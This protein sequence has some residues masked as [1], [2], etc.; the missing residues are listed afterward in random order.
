M[1]H[2]ESQDSVLRNL[3]Y[4]LT[5]SPTTFAQLQPSLLVALEK[6][7]D[8]R[9]NQPWSHRLLPT[10]SATLPAVID[11][12][13]DDS[14]ACGNPRSRS[15]SWLEGMDKLT[16]GKSST[17]DYFLSGNGREDDAVGK[18][19]RAVRKK[20]Q[21]IEALELKQFKGQALDSQQLAK[22]ETKHELE[23]A[24]SLLESGILPPTVLQSLKVKK[25]P[26]VIIEKSSTGEVGGD[27]DLKH[28][29]HTGRRKSKGLASRGQGNPAPTVS[30][31]SRSY[32]DF[33]LQ[34]QSL[35]FS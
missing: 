33:D 6:V 32:E 14:D 8:S 4:I 12:E 15:F 30:K 3:D 31:E 23:E 26:G 2:L 9:S 21:Q 10:P 1:W 13:E 18:Q 29:P 20:L 5:I 16:V 28:G 11:S 27:T 34:V 25:S 17:E 24:L 22:I 19:L 7:L 35:H